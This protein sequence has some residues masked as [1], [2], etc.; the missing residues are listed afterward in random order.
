[1]K[2]VILEKEHFEG[3]FPVIRLFDQPGN[4]ITVFTS[5]ETL[6]R[7]MDLLG[8]AAGRYQWTIL[9]TSG[10]VSFF[11]ALY[12]QLRQ[13]RPDLLYINTISD[14]HLLYALVLRQLHLPRV[15]M[16]VHDINC[17]FESKPSFGFRS[18]IIHRG[19]K[20][21]VR[22]VNEFNV[23]SD[24]MLP[25]LKSRVGGKPT[26][27]V[28]GAVFE[29]RAVQ[30]MITERI[31]LVI[32]GSLDRKRRDYEQVFELA[33]LAGQNSLPLDLVLLG[34]PHDDYGQGIIAR[35]SEMKGSPVQL[36][37]YAEAVVDQA[38]FDRQMDEAHFVWI[39]SV[40]TTQICGS[41]P[42]TYGITKSSG[43]I[44]DV[45]KH[46]KPFIVPANLTIPHNLQSS[47]F[48][49]QGLDSLASFLGHLLQSPM[50]YDRWQ[51][52]ALQNSRDY[53]IEGVRKRNPSLF[54]A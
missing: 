21:L 54:E 46:A 34:G 2:I 32:P 27:N 7:F 25:Y 22:Q 48:Q 3:A 44:F 1:M 28:P 26:H 50:E 51:L 17:L 8:P 13:Q 31:R 40:V 5:A 6:Q 29:G 16:T 52:E 30:Q 42:E 20:K 10:K 4:D 9:P 15:I 23:V 12:I 43:N 11:H 18:Q 53:T 47:C 41:I 35:A 33:R 36:F 39:P 24:T 38:E 37:T 45:I 14:N 19:K 49:Y